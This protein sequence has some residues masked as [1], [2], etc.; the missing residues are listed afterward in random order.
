MTALLKVQTEVELNSMIPIISVIIPTF[1]DW[2]G[3]KS[4]LAALAFQD[5]DASRYEIIIANNNREKTLPENIGSASNVRFIWEPKPGSYAARNTA[6]KVA[7]GEFIF[8][9]DSG[10]LPSKRWL[11]AG[12]AR[13]LSEEGCERVAGRIA[14]SPEGTTWNGWNVYD[15]VTNLRQDEYVKRGHAVTANLAVRRS[16]FEHVGLFRDDRFS[17][18]DFEW[19]RRAN[20]ENIPIVFEEEMVVWHPARKSYLEC[21]AKI[22]RI[23]GARF[24]EKCNQPVLKRIP[25]LKY[26]IPSIRKFRKIWREVPEAPARVRFLAML[27]DYQMGWVYNAEIVRLGF[28]GKKPSRS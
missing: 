28:F 10:C 2:P 15:H 24:T 5:I 7:R 22:R 21:A 14:V 9:T 19:N 13:F 23:A 18:G 25:R 1:E 17:G 3:V 4:S 6:I 20:K 27:Y 11:S 12:L 8:F 26:L 16:A